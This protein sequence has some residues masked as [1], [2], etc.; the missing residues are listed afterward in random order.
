MHEVYLAIRVYI[1]LGFTFGWLALQ[2]LQ[3]VSVELIPQ[4]DSGALC[5]CLQRQGGRTWGSQSL[6]EGPKLHVQ[7]LEV[8]QLEFHHG[9]SLIMWNALQVI[10]DN[11]MTCSAG[12]IKSS[13]A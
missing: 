1:C 11:V 7:Y 8:P 2:H 12:G 13:H 4:S 5:Q 10:E 9:Q 3:S 6:V